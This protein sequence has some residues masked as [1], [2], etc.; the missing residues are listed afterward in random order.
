VDEDLELWKRLNV[1]S[2]NHTFENFRATPLNEAAFYAMQHLATGDSSK[3]F[4]LLYGVPGSGK[5]HLIEA[6]CIVRQCRYM[7]MSQLMR[8][9][10]QS[11]RTET[12]NDQFKRFCEV[13][14][15]VIDDYGG[16]VQETKFEIADIEDI[17]N[18]RYH[19]RYFSDGK[20]TILATNQ[21]IKS[22]PERVV[23]RFRD[24]EFGCLVL[25]EETDYGKRK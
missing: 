4:V 8:L 20:I 13:P 19:K 1:S 21:D 16:G 18:E 24:P 15:L 22:L 6:F 5:T 25:N 7:A 23:R 10:K 11:L 17:V 3:K 12:Y 14:I 2:L 9:L